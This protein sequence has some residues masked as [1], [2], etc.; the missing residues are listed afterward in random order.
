MTMKKK[1]KRIIGLRLDFI[2]WDETTKKKTQRCVST[3]LT[4]RL[5]DIF[6]FIYK[7]KKKEKESISFRW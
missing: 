5:V 4:Y 6:Q 2:V 7:R 3:R 1:S